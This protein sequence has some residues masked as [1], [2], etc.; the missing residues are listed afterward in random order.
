MVNASTY[1]VAVSQF[2][3]GMPC[4]AMER[5]V[6]LLDVII[7]SV[8]SYSACLN[9]RHGWKVNC[10]M[11]WALHATVKTT[12]VG[13]RGHTP[14]GRWDDRPSHQTEAHP[15]P[16][17]CDMIASEYPS[18]QLRSGL[19]RK[20]RL[21]LLWICVPSCLFLVGATTD[22]TWSCSRVTHTQFWLTLPICF[23]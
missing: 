8:V 21:R 3:S 22:S 16:V 10:H 2:R 19:G 9:S 6:W 13:W 4:K 7:T 17:S 14:Y 23:L 15:S 20:R 1:A 11:S 12:S 18:T 5:D